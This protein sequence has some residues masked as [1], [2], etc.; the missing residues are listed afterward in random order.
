MSIVDDLKNRAERN[1]RFRIKG[2]V[3]LEPLDLGTKNT[4]EKS[5]SDFDWKSILDKRGSITDEPS[6]EIIDA[7]IFVIV[8]YLTM[9][10][11]ISNQSLVPISEI[12]NRA[13]EIEKNIKSISSKL[14]VISS[15]FE[16]IY[17]VEL[18]F[19]EWNK[20]LDAYALFVKEDTVVKGSR[21]TSSNE[22]LHL[23]IDDLSY[24]YRVHTGKPAPH[25]ISGG[26]AA[27]GTGPFLRLIAQCLEIAGDPLPNPKIANAIEQV[28]GSGVIKD[29]ILQSP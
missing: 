14:E 12:G 5:V 1:S 9:K 22:P 13:R 16:A 24:V 18:S 2:L 15:D 3:K 20:T 23:L 29:K 11:L 27:D 4:I 10:K 7:L 21:G 19:E 8:E 25:K 28:L 17:G 6:D 26:N